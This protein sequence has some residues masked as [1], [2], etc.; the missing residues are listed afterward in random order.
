MKEVD[1][2]LGRGVNNYWQWRRK[3]ETR[4]LLLSVG[5]NWMMVAPVMNGWA[6]LVVF[7]GIGVR[8]NDNGVVVLEIRRKNK[9]RTKSCIFSYWMWVSSFFKWFGLD[10]LVFQVRIVG[11]WQTWLFQ[12]SGGCW[13][14]CVRL[15]VRGKK[16]YSS[17]A[18]VF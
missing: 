10:A 14:G 15:M 8:K 5:R 4:L 6:R 13:C 18:V 3:W 1:V 7:G 12:V 17:N 2:T 11:W 16:K 9:D